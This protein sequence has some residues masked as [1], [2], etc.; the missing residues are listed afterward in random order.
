MLPGLESGRI[1]DRCMFEEIAWCESAINCIIR[2]HL[3][4][5]RSIPGCG[6]E[7]YGT[8]NNPDNLIGLI[9]NCSSMKRSVTSKNKVVGVVSEKEKSNTQEPESLLDK[10][11]LDAAVGDAIK[12][13]W[14]DSGVQVAVWLSQS[15]PFHGTML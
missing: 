13:F 5:K 12:D 10:L 15:L 1:V 3:R 4:E 11:P 2:M 9:A 7:I 8:G 6:V 14:Q